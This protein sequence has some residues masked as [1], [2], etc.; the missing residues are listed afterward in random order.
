ME[1]DESADENGVVEEDVTI[2]EDVMT[3]DEEGMAAPDEEQP[4]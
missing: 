1:T 4:Q 2:E 3:D